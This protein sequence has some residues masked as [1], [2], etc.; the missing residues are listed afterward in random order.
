MMIRTRVFELCDGRY[1]NLTELA[2]AMG[3]STQFLGSPMTLEARI[4]GV[5]E[6]RDAGWLM[7]QFHYSVPMSES[8]RLGS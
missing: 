5:F 6:K 3:I 4:T 1:S 8:I 7:V 2:Q